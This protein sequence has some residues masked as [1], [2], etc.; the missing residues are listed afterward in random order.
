V[1][2]N[3]CQFLSHLANYI[4][5]L[6]SAIR[7]MLKRLLTQVWPYINHCL[8][9]LAYL[10]MQTRLDVL[11]TAA[12]LDS[13]RCLLDRTIFP[14]VRRNNLPCRDLVPSMWGC[15]S[16]VGRFHCIRNLV[17]LNG[18][19]PSYGVIIKGLLK[20]RFSTLGPNTLTSIFCQN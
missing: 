19:S 13:L 8:W 14:G 1:V 4:G 16:Y 18:V 2:Y 10:L 7:D 12:L 5:K 20:I 3:V 9:E 6:L 11:M 17:F 15:W